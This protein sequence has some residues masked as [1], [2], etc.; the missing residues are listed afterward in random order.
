MGP[1]SPQVIGAFL[2]RVH[3]L[4]TDPAAAGGRLSFAEIGRR[5]RKL[6]LRPGDLVILSLPNGA[7]LLHHFFGVL[8]AGGVPA[9]AAPD[10]PVARLRE[11]A[12]VMGA[13]AVGKHFLTA[14]TLGSEQTAA[15]DQVGVAWFPAAAVPAARPGEVVLF[16]SGTS[17]FASGCLFTLE[18]L[19]RNATRHAEAIGQRAD[20]TVLVNLPLHFSFALVAQTLATLVRG[21]RLVITGPPFHPPTYMRCLAAYG[22]T[23]SSLTPVLVRALPERD[24]NWPDSLRVLTVGGD[25]LAPERVQQLLRR[26]P[27]RELYLTY[28]LTQ[29]GPRVATLAAHREPSHRHGSVGQPLAGTRVILENLDG[30]TGMQQLLVSSDTLMQ[31]RIG[32]LEGCSADDWRS[33]GVLA[34]GDAFEQDAAGY[35]YFRGRLA[36]WIVRRGEKICL[37]AIRRVAGQLPQV[38]RAHTQVVRLANGEADFD[39]TL[40]T[41]APP[42][43]RGVDYRTE[44]HRFLRRGEMPRT[45]Q[46]VTNDSPLSFPYK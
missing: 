1:L 12:G 44:L 36:D 2:E 37:A 42:S 10:L 21:G 8:A 26:R 20:D 31:R 23:V 6:G 9:M 5:W 16:T 3:D 43:P 13:R 14:G 27:G 7:E 34:T 17:G 30:A 39:L 28:G 46:V 24:Q 29:A 11:L 25:A 41:G 40:V 22:V 15:M 45:I 33:P 35:L 4:C 32:R 18:A 38:V 19:L